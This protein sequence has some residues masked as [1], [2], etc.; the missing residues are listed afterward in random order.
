MTFRVI[1]ANTLQDR[2]EGNLNH[3]QN[4]PL[5]WSQTILGPVINEGERGAENFFKTVFFCV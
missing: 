4:S 2:A 1:R 5:T 3:K